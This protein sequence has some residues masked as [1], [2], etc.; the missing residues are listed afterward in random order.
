VTAASKTAPNRGAV[1]P[2]DEQYGT[3]TAGYLSPEDLVTGQKHD[4]LN[5]GYSAIAPSVFREAC[6]RWRDTLPAVAGRAE[7]YSFVD[8][9]A[10]KG[11]A[12]LLASELPFR[13]I[14]GVELNP[15]LARIAQR[16]LARWRRV[17]GSKTSIR[18]VQEDAL[19]FRWPRPPLL[20]Y[21]YNP[22][23]CSLIARLAEKL[24]ALSSS[25]A[26]SLVDILYVNPTCTDVLTTNGAFSRLW[27]AR[28]D[29]DEADR[30][31]DPYGTA[32]DLVSVYRR[33]R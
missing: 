8:V 10:G 32:T 19:N 12:L 20:V 6:R 30:K 24:A 16:N 13:K 18:A 33:A 17:T 22:F 7:A 28:I 15:D 5:Y 14:I 26:S 23:D 1:H 11:R 27:T 25:S 4:A 3:D 21:L 29:M 2:F 31:A 9:G